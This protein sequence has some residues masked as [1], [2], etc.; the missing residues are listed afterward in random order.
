[1]AYGSADARR[2]F[3]DIPFVIAGGLATRLYMAER[4]TLHIDVLILPVDRTRAETALSG[5]GCGKTGALTI[6][7][8]TWDLPDGRSLDLIALDEP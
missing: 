4:M 2:Y 3:G 7:G 8:S 6:G 5:A 1:M